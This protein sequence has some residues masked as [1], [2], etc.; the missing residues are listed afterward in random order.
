MTKPSRGAI[1]TARVLGCGY[2]DHVCR[3]PLQCA[4]MRR[5][6]A[7]PRTFEFDTPKPPPLLT[8]EERSAMARVLTD[9]GMTQGEA[10]MTL[11]F[12]MP[13]VASAIQRHRDEAY[14]DGER[15][16]MTRMVNTPGNGDMGG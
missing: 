12:M 5:C 6:L 15:G 8:D 16:G 3:T 2:E 1:G 13:Q 7:P 14:R 4:D 10:D 9:R 11:H